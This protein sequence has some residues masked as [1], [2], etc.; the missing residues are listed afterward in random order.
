MIPRRVDVEK[1]TEAVVALVNSAY[2]VETGSEG[3][4]FK[5]M[6]RFEGYPPDALLQTMK[7]SWVIEE[8]GRIVGVVRLA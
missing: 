8:E 5:K 3:I 1:D 4:A 6:K 7:E 2:D